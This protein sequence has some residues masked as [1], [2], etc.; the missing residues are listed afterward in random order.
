MSQNLWIRREVLEIGWNRRLLHPGGSHPWSRIIG[1]S[2]FGWRPGDEC[3][4]WRQGFDRTWCQ[5]LGVYAV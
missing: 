2:A 3:Q 1:I 5:L 4:T